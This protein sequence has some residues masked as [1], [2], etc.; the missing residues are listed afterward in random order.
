MR[1]MAFQNE[2]AKRNTIRLTVA[3]NLNMLRATSSGGDA[4]SNR[5]SRLCGALLAALLANLCVVTPAGATGPDSRAGAVQIIADMRRIVTPQGIEETRSVRI[6]GIDQWISVRGTDRRNPVLL[7]LHGGPGYVA[8]PTSWYFQRG[9]EEYFTVVQWDQ[10]GAGKTYAANDPAKVAPTMTRARMLQDAE[11][12]V[13]WLRKTFGKERIFVL[14]HSWGSSLGIQLAQRHP[15]W[16]H[17]YIG[18]G[19]ITDGMESERRGWRFAID[20]ARRDGNARA[21]HELESIA[22]YAAAGKPLVL[23]DLY[24]QRKWLGHYGGAVYGRTDFEAESNAVRLAPEYSDAEL[25]TLWE[26]TE[27]SSSRMLTDVLSQDFSTITRFACPIVIFNGRHDYNVS[28]SATAEWFA[29]VEAPSRQLVWFE[30][31]AHEMFNEEPGKTLVSLVRYARPFAEKAGD[32]A[33]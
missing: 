32:A 22:P 29:K 10:R 8:M 7:M 20:A 27:F 6:G 2:T 3:R 16:L 19:Q 23:K 24:L 4:M 21:V 11:E 12:M 28:A 15:D 18:L 17:A 9:W 33:P 25:R 1:F 26:G 14:G 13:A 5:S 31:S 30:H